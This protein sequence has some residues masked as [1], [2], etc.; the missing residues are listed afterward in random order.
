MR[1]ECEILLKEFL[2]YLEA[3]LKQPTRGISSRIPENVYTVN[4]MDDLKG[5]LAGWRKNI[6]IPGVKGFTKLIKTE[7]DNIII[8]SNLDIPKGL[9]GTIASAN[10]I[11]A[12]I[13]FKDDPFVTTQIDIGYTLFKA[14]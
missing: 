5:S 8:F 4:F 11:S 2:R 10:N 1:E 3:E 12:R 9:N 6:I 14:V 7:E 13:L